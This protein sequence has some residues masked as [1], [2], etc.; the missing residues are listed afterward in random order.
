MKKIYKNKQG[1]KSM[2]GILFAILCT[3]SSWLS[4]QISGTKTL[5]TGGDYTTWES[6]VS[7]ISTSGMNGALT[8]DVISDLA[9]TTT[10]SFSQNAT[11]PTT[12]TKTIKINGGNYKLSSS[13]TN[14]AIDLNG[15]DYL[16]IDKLVIQKTGTGTAQFGVIFRGGADY[17][18]IQNCTIEYTALASASTA[19]GAYISFTNST[20][21]ATTLASTVYNGRYNT[22]DKCLMRTTSSN[23]PGP[24]YAITDAG[25]SSIYSNTPSNNT[26]SNNTIQNYYYMGMYNYYTN[27]DQFLNNDVSRANATTNNC[28]SIQYFMYSQYTYSTNRST[29]F[30]GNNVHDIPFKGATSGMTSTVYGIY[31]YYNYGNATN[32][33]EYSN[34]TMQNILCNSTNYFMYGYYNYYANYNANKVIK[35]QSLGTGYC[36]GFYMYYQYND[37]KFTNNII[38]DCFTK[39][40]TYFIYSFYG[41]KKIFTGNK[42]V[43]NV[44]TDGSTAE[45]YVYYI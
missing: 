16:T 20:T 31:A 38:R 42:I 40:Y 5:G 8:I 10:I 17:N 32:N 29:K 3:S 33:F 26:F 34:N 37:H 14:A 44:T 9:P 4:G 27:G 39:Y 19:G 13:S 6:L 41:D 22:I 18:T 7:A 45:T 35:W 25:A 11:N 24:T 15:M 23:S 30:D 12:S 36:Y 2:R 43:N 28:N 21:G 1:L